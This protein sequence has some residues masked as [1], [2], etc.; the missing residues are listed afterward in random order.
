MLVTI[1]PPVDDL[2]LD[3]VRVESEVDLVLHSFAEAV[4]LVSENRKAKA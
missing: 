1:R 3:E 4:A 2:F